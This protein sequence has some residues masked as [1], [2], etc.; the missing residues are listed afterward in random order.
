MLF[1]KT[2]IAMKTTVKR[3]L[4]PTVTTLMFETEQFVC[5]QSGFGDIEDF[6]EDP[7]DYGDFFE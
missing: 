7:E 5:A 4:T 3:Y 2:F 1:I 6:F